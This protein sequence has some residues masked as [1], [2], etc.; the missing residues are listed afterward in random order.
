[1]LEVRECALCA[2][3]GQDFFCLLL[4][5]TEFNLV[6][7]RVDHEGLDHTLLEGQIPLRFTCPWVKVMTVEGLVFDLE[8]RTDIQKEAGHQFLNLMKQNGLANMSVTVGLGDILTLSW[9]GER[10]PNRSSTYSSCPVC[11]SSGNLA[12]GTREL[13][14]VKANLNPRFQEGMLGKCCANPACASFFINTS[15]MPYLNHIIIGQVRTNYEQLHKLKNDT[16][17][18]HAQAREMRVPP[19]IWDPCL[20][21]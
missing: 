21:Q 16:R 18:L 10:H 2:A 19:D 8:I 14:E 17:V 9:F 7:E 4:C 15:Y 20:E 13:P 5:G 1:M 12:A 11:F 3:R 6:N